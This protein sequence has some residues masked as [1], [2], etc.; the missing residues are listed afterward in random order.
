MGVKRRTRARVAHVGI[1]A[2]TVAGLLVVSGC[3]DPSG[4][5]EDRDQALAALDRATNAA[6]LETEMGELITVLAKN[7]SE[8]K[9]RRIQRRLASLDSRAAELLADAEA[10]FNVELAPV[11]GSGVSGSA[12]LAEADGELALDAS[13]DGLTDGQA[14]HVS[15]HALGEGAGSSVC[16]PADAEAGGDKVLS[17]DEAADF[18]GPEV[19][20]FGEA[21]DPEV[22]SAGEAAEASPVTVRALVVSGGK[23]KNGFD[24]EMPVAC[25]VPA[26][27]A[28]GGDATG[29]AATVLATNEL[30][31]AAADLAAGASDLSSRRSRRAQARAEKRI[32]QVNRDL[33]QGVAQAQET[34]E[35]SGDVTAD[36]Q[37][38]I[39]AAL[40]ELDDAATTFDEGFVA[41]ETTVEELEA[42]AAERARQRR[43]AQ[44]AAL[45]PSEPSAPSAPAPAPAPAPG[46]SVVIE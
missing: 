7:P 36:D 42:E 20:D 35:R 29:E 5:D 18:Y 1:A 12:T 27:A 3:D 2:I 17:A 6:A 33:Q 13:L 15:L 45:A 41:L 24:P 10:T 19:I 23:G 31:G 43:E 28:G 30:R 38:T 26:A 4:G 8:A 39:D 16:P 32:Q 46:P 22:L 40:T 37:Q 44:Q 11:N 9:Q 25:G 34:L 21:S 14:H